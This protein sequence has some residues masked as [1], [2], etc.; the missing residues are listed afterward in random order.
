MY[1]VKV[2]P[3]THTIA[4]VHAF[5][6][7][8]ENALVAKEKGLEA[9]AMTDH[10]GEDFLPVSISGKNM[11]PAAMNLK[12][13]PNEL[14]GVKTLMG[15]EIDIVDKDGHLYGWNQVM[16]EGAYKGMIQLDA[17]LS[18]RE[19]TIAS[20]HQAIVEGEELTKGEGTRMYI[21][22]LQTPGVHIL[23]HIGRPKVPFDIEVVVKEAKKLGKII[24]INNH[25]FGFGEKIG[26][27][28]KEIALAC[29]EEGTYITVSSD[30]HSA[31]HIGE[32]SLTLQM[33]KEIDFPQ[34]LIANESLEK[35]LGIIKKANEMQHFT[36]YPRRKNE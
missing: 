18:T 8:G 31:H 14:F 35:L 21:N 19:I 25:S 27:R 24:E 12:S 20:Y 15:T 26:K 5:S 16:F 33:L 7:L 30:A 13:F 2:D 32:F 34:K 29:A 10:F 11:I 1:T 3:H 28:C 9:I 6:T 17:L 22:V 4:S 23:G 36:P